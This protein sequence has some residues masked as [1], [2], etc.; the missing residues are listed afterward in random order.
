MAAPYDL[1]HI[2]LVRRLQAAPFTSA[3][4]NQI[5]AGT[6]R[7]REV[8]GEKLRGELAAS[9]RAF[10]AAR[11]EDPRLDPPQGAFLEVE[12]KRGS[13]VE[14]VERKDD[15]IKPGAARREPNDNRIVGMYVPD[16]SREVFAE[17]LREYQEGELTPRGKPRRR[18]FVEPIES[19]RAARLETFW[20][21]DPSR[22]PA[23]GRQM[24]WEV[25]CVRELED[26]LGQLIARLGARTA[27]HEQRLYF[28]EHVVLPVLAD[29]AT[30]ELMLFARLSIVELRRAS[31]S[32]AFFLDDIDR[33]EQRDV[34][35]E[36]SERTEWP[37]MDVP[38]VCLLDTGV[39][40]AHI[41][42]EPTLAEADMAA[43]NAEWGVA[44]SA[45]GHGTGMAGLALFGDLTPHL[46][47]IDALSLTHRLESVKI[48]PPDG[49][50]PTEER[51]YGAITKQAVALPESVR[52][53]RP[54]VF[55]LAVTNE[56]RAGNRPTTWSAAIDQEAAGVTEVGEK[57]P[58]R[59]FV[60]SA[61]NVPEEIAVDRITDPDTLEIEDPAQAWNAITVGGYTDL[62]NIQ[63]PEFEGYSPYA[64][65]GDISP[66]TRTLTSWLQGKAP[67]KPDIVMEAGNRVVS[68]AKTDTYD[69]DSLALLS[70][71]PNTDRQP[72]VSFRATSA[73]TAQAARLAARLTAA[74]PDYWPETIRA[75]MIHG[76]EWTPLMK[77]ALTAAA[78]KSAA[79]LLL[80][81]YG[82]GVPTF[83][84]AA[85]SARNH[86]AM[87]SQAEIQP[88]SRS[89]RGMNEC[90]FY[91]LPWPRAALE[92]L[93]EQDVTLKITLSYFV[94]PNPG[95]SAAFDPYRYQS[96]GLRFD[97][98]RRSE[99]AINFAKR[100]N[101][102]VW[103]Q[104]KDRPSTDPD[105]D[106]WL[107]GTQSMS[108]GSL[109]SDEWTG[110]AV[111]LLSRDIICIKPVG[112]WWK[113]R[114]KAEVRGQKARYSLV[115]SLRS[116]DSEVDL[117]T[118]ISTLIE[119]EVG[120]Q[121]IAIPT[122]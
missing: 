41:L 113:D 122:S 110:P 111:N 29:R 12:L 67:F 22:L 107:F 49:F 47:G 59:L 116:H 112:G 26:E 89:G 79:Y 11:H 84:R 82:H 63:E 14:V 30:I 56:D 48:L 75:L 72:L 33:D 31:D 103:E 8:H 46:A 58:P 32:P 50:D 5:G 57:V 92:S 81:R 2:D 100:L 38:A 73:A 102:Q 10:D 4:S 106:R 86:L 54:R 45:H 97:L 95:S 52:P 83:Q 21:D 34:S 104:P 114:A 78:N 44:D 19:I 53:D 69:A 85:A 28:P 119:T 74:F 17:I 37:G 91:S 42:I 96:Y 117:Y 51:F 118:P 71:G 35:E 60:V 115:L 25:W 120:V 105:G 87:I 18:T 6:P 101:K 121:A 40:R 16:E 65:A 13:R 20:T 62:I 70:T 3:A 108:A 98:K 61:G 24:W 109:H 68:P 7:S 15:G 80:R 76:A 88:Y 43:V 94:E 93:G 90:H 27:D 66:Y 36:L 9:Y 23:P 1:P 99:T 55:C 77:G 64:M 39:N